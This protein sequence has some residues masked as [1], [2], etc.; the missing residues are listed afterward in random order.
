M[1][2]F[3]RATKGKV[4]E[5]SVPGMYDIMETPNQLKG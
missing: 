2:N 5:V 3:K 1:E 4:N